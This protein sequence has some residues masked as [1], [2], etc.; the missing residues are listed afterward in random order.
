MAHARVHIKKGFV[1]NSIKFSSFVIL[2][3]QNTTSAVLLFER[4]EKVLKL[5]L[6]KIRVAL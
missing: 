2:V 5:V 3:Q 1:Q 6:L 4:E